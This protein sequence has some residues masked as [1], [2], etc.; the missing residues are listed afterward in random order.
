MGLGTEV[1]GRQGGTADKHVS[2]NLLIFQSA[3]CKKIEKKRKSQ[4]E[5]THFSASL[6]K[7]VFHVAAQRASE[8]IHALKD[9]L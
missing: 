3:V 6:E 2:R 8:G 9:I 5:Q 7:S 4:G 1:G